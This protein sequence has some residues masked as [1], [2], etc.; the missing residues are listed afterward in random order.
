[1]NSRKQI[2]WCDGSF[3]SLRV[4]AESQCV[5]LAAPAPR[6]T[7]SADKGCN[8]WQG[9]VCQSGFFCLFWGAGLDF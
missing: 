9:S 8:Y 1:M 3:P 7:R 2:R 6:E 5:K 4:K